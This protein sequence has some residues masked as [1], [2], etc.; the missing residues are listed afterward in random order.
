MTTLIFVRHGQSQSNLEKRFTGQ[1]NTELTEL[2]RLQAERTADFLREYPIDAVYASDLHRAMDTAAP[3]ARLHG[4][5]VI[6]DPMLRE[7]MAGD[8]EGKYYDD[9]LMEYPDS[10]PK[11]LNDLGHAH[12]EGGESVVEVAERVYAEVDRLLE[13]HRGGCIAL[14]SHATPA[15]LMGC[16]WFGYAPEDAARMTGCGNASVS[17]VEYDDE[18]TFHVV[19]YGY[20]EHQGEFATRLPGKLG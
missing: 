20:D 13:R 5:E 6:P 16:R 10:F 2:G 17:V 4:L 11:W 9:L 3:T 12:P 18:M 15:R 7:V 14:F 1:G 8:W 19:H